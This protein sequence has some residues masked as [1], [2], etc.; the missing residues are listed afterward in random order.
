MYSLEDLFA[1]D[2]KEVEKNVYEMMLKIETT[3][4]GGK[5]HNKRYV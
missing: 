3:A 1:M 4:E 2:P 5:T